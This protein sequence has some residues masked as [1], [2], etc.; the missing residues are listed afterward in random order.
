LVVGSTINEH[1]ATMLKHARCDRHHVPLFHPG[2]VLWL[3]ATLLSFIPAL[4]EYYNIQQAHLHSKS[5]TTIAVFGFSCEAFMGVRPSVALFR[6]F[7]CMRVSTRTSEILGEFP[8][9][10][11]IPSS[12][13]VV[14]EALQLPAELGVGGRW[15]GCTPP[16]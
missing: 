7:W 11:S 15:Q 14:K 12:W 1:G 4:L 6:H 3:G 13:E 8:F 10:Q 2:D 16:L 5:L 9:M